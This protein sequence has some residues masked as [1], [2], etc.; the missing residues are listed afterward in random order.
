MK[1]EHG[2]CGSWFI[3][4]TPHDNLVQNGFNTDYKEGKKGPVLPDGIFGFRYI[5]NYGAFP[6]LFG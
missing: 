5:A 3:T 1:I 4:Y 6:K 2:S